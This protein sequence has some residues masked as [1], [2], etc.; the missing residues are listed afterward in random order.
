MEYTSL[1]T[2]TA[3]D[4]PRADVLVACAGVM[5]LVI[6]IAAVGMLIRVLSR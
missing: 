4:G 5:S 6:I 1:I 3:F 2:A